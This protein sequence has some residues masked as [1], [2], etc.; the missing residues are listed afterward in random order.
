MEANGE[1]GYPLVPPFLPIPTLLNSPMWVLEER[2]KR[3]LLSVEVVETMFLSLSGF[4]PCLAKN[5]GSLEVKGGLFL[6]EMF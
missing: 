1:S 5:E 3:D 2:F 4:S 6:N